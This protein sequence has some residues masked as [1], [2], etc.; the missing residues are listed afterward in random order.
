MRALRRGSGGASGI[1][2]GSPLQSCRV[3]R[4]PACEPG[5]YLASVCVTV[6]Y[7]IPTFETSITPTSE[8]ERS[9]LLSVAGRSCAVRWGAWAGPGGME[10]AQELSIDI[11]DKAA[12]PILEAEWS[13]RRIDASYDLMVHRLG[14]GHFSEVRLALRRETKQRVAVKMM[15]KRDAARAAR[16]QSE[17]AILHMVMRL[18]HPNLMRL[19][20]VFETEQEVMLVCELLPNGSLLDLLRRDGALHEVDARPVIRQ[21]TSGLQA[22]HNMGVVHRDLKPENILFDANGVLKLV[23]FGFAKSRSARSDV[24]HLGA[25]DATTRFASSPCGTPGFVAPEVLNRSIYS[26]APALALAPP[27]RPRALRCASR[28]CGRFCGYVVAWRD[29]LHDSLWCSALY[30]SLQRLVAHPRSLRAP[31]PGRRR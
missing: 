21:I 17:V 8:S 4:G 10:S 27:R 7:T 18:Q 28:L 3:V 31:G 19:Y 23:D 13:S 5:M 12:E 15:V 16:I 14:R 30:R 1:L 29:H 6:T 20:D 22:L 24:A 11:T 26:C 2:R 25:F 9:E